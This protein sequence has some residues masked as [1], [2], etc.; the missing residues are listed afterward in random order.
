MLSPTPD[1]VEFDHPG[2][3]VTTVSAPAL[4]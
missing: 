3:N 1:V 4:P 2:I